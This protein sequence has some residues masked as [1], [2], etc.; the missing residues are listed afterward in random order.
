MAAADLFC[1]NHYDCIG[2][3]M[4]HTFVQYNKPQMLQVSISCKWLKCLIH[5]WSMFSFIPP[6]NTRK[7]KVFSEVFRGYQREH[8]PQMGQ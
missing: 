5:F 2:F 4:D 8:W 3:D 1:M 7:L 6:E